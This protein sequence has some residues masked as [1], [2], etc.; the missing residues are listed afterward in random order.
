MLLFLFIGVAA[1]PELSLKTE[2][3]LQS[4]NCQKYIC[5]GT[6]PM[7]PN[8]CIYYGGEAYYL[9]ECTNSPNLYCPA[10]FNLLNQT[11]TVPPSPTSQTAYPGEY[12]EDDSWCLYGTCKGGLCYG[13][14]YG[15][16][17]QSHGECNKGLR[18]SN[19]KCV[20]QIAVN[21]T[22]CVN[23][24]DCVNNAGC[25]INTCREYYSVANGDWV[26]MCENSQSQICGSGF[27][28]Y[29]LCQPAIKNSQKLPQ[30]CYSN[31]DCVSHELASQGITL[32][33][34]CQCGYGRNALSY[35]TLFPGD[36]PF[37]DLMKIYKKWISSKDAL[38]CN[39]ARRWSTG[40][41]KTMLGDNAAEEFDY[42]SY[43]V[44]YFPQVQ[45]VDE[46]ALDI[47]FPAYSAEVSDRNSSGLW[48]C[49]GMALYGALI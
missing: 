27:C 47:I 7:N 15:S 16:N 38:N 20:N 18:C 45:K 9:Q 23:D 17:C 14:E 10:V 40:C 28:V 39:T 32:Y 34:T 6:K 37:Q 49:I 22:G 44:T 48:I 13:Q 33:T 25:D 41:V 2:A 31:S 35:C 5:G 42:Y 36:D 46:C 24:Y 30:T 11:C 1:F 12:C 3:N 29:G 26:D 21:Q 19:G 8:T 43:K 4:L